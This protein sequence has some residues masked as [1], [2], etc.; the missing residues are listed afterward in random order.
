MSGDTQ[1]HLDGWDKEANAIGS[2]DGLPRD[3]FLGL[4][5]LRAL[6]R[7]MS[8]RADPAGRISDPAAP[9]LEAV[10][11]DLPALA[12]V[13]LAPESLDWRASIGLPV[14]ARRWI[15]D[16]EGEGDGIPL[17]R[18]ALEEGRVI[19]L[20][21]GGGGRDPRLAK[22]RSVRPELSVLALVPLFDGNQATGVLAL[23]GC[24]SKVLSGE[25]LRRLAPVF[26]LLGVLVGWHRH[27]TDRAGWE[28]LN[29]GYA[30]LEVQLEAMRARNAEVEE[31]FR[32]VGDLVLGADSNG[33][34]DLEAAQARIGELETDLA[35]LGSEVEGARL[36][37]KA[38]EHLESS[39]ALDAVRISELEFEIERLG[40]ALSDT[41][42]DEGDA[43]YEGF[44]EDASLLAREA[45]ATAV[46]LELPN[47]G[48]IELGEIAAQAEAALATIP[49]SLDEQ[50]DAR[51]DR[52]EAL[53]SRAAW[54]PRPVL[55]HLEAEAEMLER[56]AEFG[57]NAGVAVFHGA[58]EAPLATT[59]LVAANLFAPEVGRVREAV[60]A[61]GGGV[62]GVAYAVHEGSGF[63]LGAVGWMTRPIDPP[64]ALAFLSE[65]ESETARI[66]LVS[67]QLRELAPLRDALAEAKAAAAV[68]CDAKQALDL[69]EIVHQPD[70]IMIDL[71]LEGGQGLG[72][73]SQLRSQPSTEEI[74]LFLLLP[75]EPD[76]TRFLADAAEASLLGPYGA[77]DLDL[78]VRG[79][80]AP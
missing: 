42:L 68:A 17:A 71:Q 40:R 36:E 60:S 62:Q 64:R 50:E 29:P 45:E 76:P 9:L 10:C 21:G 61:V 66:L 23:G 16:V 34:A 51:P 49:G 48:D 75:E 6:V 47:E 20:G 53:V 12:V 11:R 30:E 31:V 73:A 80:F 77:D 38:R 54:L 28:G 32:A 79:A 59:T 18:R 65:A 78:L 27:A 43:S 7:S 4:S 39:A 15:M 41:A 74:P 14:E 72:L 46:A 24:D 37:L 33:Q 44:S 70:A 1:P 19:L 52:P 26:R 55:W 5:L 25:E 2:E 56:V 57:A 67:G 13:L 22:L 3:R 8:A 58:G 35:R 69:L 63:A